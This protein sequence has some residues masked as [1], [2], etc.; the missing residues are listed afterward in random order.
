MGSDSVIEPSRI[1][2]RRLMLPKG[3]AR[4]NV[5]SVR[6]GSVEPRG[7]TQWRD[8]PLSTCHLP[9]PRIVASLDL[10]VNTMSDLQKEVG[11]VCLLIYGMTEPFTDR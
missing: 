6:C 1:V 4:R 5:A 7:A 9:S 10:R 11:Q 2:P 8:F 3:E